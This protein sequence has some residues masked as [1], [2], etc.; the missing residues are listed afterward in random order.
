MSSFC[1]KRLDSE[2]LPCPQLEREERE[3]CQVLRTSHFTTSLGVSG[4]GLPLVF[5]GWLAVMTSKNNF[6]FLSLNPGRWVSCLLKQKYSTK[7]TC[8][9]YRD[10]GQQFVERVLLLSPPLPAT[11]RVALEN[12]RPLLIARSFLVAIY[13]AH[14]FHRWCNDR[15]L[16]QRQQQQDFPKVS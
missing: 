14:L 4:N 11:Y 3:T 8:I 7:P 2:V 1:V 16:T 9:T 6:F 12:Q 5:Q 15:H 10:I 13:Q